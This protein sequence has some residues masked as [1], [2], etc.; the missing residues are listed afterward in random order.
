MWKRATPIWQM[1][2]RNDTSCMRTFW[3]GNFLRIKKR[4]KQV[5][6]AE[7][8]IKFFIIRLCCWKFFHIYLPWYSVVV[9]LSNKWF[10]WVGFLDSITKG[11]A[12]NYEWRLTLLPVKEYIFSSTSLGSSKVGSFGVVTFVSAFVITSSF[13]ENK[14]LYLVF[15]TRCKQ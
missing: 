2:L 11:G 6:N 9:I 12:I 4:Q 7:K 15:V 10:S 3:E 14:L 8:M 13:D 5:G 1:L